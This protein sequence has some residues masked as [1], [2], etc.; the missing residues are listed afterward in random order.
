MA[1]GR[2]FS[3]IKILIQEISKPRDLIVYTDG[4][5]IKDKS[6]WAFT[7][8]Q[9]VTTIHEDNAAQKTSPSSLTVEEEAVTHALRWIAWKGDDQTTR[10][11]IL[12]GSMSLPHKKKREKKEVN[13]GIESPDCIVT[14]VDI[15]LRRHLWMWSDYRKYLPGQVIRIRLKIEKSCRL[16]WDIF[17][18]AVMNDLTE[19]FT[20]R[21]KVDAKCVY[22]Q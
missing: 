6:G 11:I 16:F 17:S 8:K 2:P 5:F 9:G 12:T 18:S 7:V 14:M 3:E 10:A 21:L 1:A 13:S 20:S 15:H 22:Q 4:S 19:T